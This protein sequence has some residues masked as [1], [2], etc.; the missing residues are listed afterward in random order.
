MYT[1]DT[2]ITKFNHLVKTFSQ[3]L[4]DIHII[5]IKIYTTWVLHYNLQTIYG[6]PTW[7]CAYETTDMVLGIH[8]GYIYEYKILGSK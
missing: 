3:L 5:F 7:G 6:R 4:H 2:N 1:L 8:L